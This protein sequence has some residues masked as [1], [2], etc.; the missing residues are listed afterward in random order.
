MFIKSLCNN[1]CPCYIRG[2]VGNHPNVRFPVHNKYQLFDYAFRICMSVNIVCS[3]HTELLF[4]YAQ[5]YFTH[6]YKLYYN[7]L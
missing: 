5:R 7:K 1:T 6:I 2:Y 4:D 3:L